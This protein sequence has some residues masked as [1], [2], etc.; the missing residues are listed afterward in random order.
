MSSYSQY[1]DEIEIA[2]TCGR[3]LSDEREA[4]SV[5]CTI[6]ERKCHVTCYPCVSQHDFKCDT[7]STHV[8]HPIPLEP[9]VNLINYV[10][11]PPLAQNRAA[12]LDVLWWHRLKTVEDSNANEN[13]KRTCSVCLVNLTKTIFIPC[14]HYC[15]CASC[16]VELHAYAD[17]NGRAMKCP[18]C[19]TLVGDVI[20]V[21]E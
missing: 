4:K 7:C 17:K 14:G 12:S 1:L 6:C 16:A 19:R 21:H 15:T 10:P 5:H 13:E 20:Q 2:C 9:D 3:F 11:P 18:T 8:L